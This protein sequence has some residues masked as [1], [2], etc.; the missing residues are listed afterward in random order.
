MVLA[1]VAVGVVMGVGLFLVW[2]H[3][4]WFSWA[5]VCFIQIPTALVWAILSYKPEVIVRI[6][7]SP[8]FE[9]A[10]VGDE[11]LHSHSESFWLVHPDG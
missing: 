2:R 7:S 3:H 5:I 8:T 6:A 11:T 4:V 9:R 10:G 1:L